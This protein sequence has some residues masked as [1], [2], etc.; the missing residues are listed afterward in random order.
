MGPHKETIRFV[1]VPGMD[2]PM[3]LGLAWLEKW[4]LYIDCKRK[5]LKILRQNPEREAPKKVK[6]SNYTPLIKKVKG[7]N[8]ASTQEWKE[9]ISA[10]SSKYWSPTTTR[11][12]D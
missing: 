12:C 2:H 5:V 11:D 4:N 7:G 6:L 8:T 9:V 1:V 3:G 10:I